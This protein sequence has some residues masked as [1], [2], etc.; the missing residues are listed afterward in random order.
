MDVNRT[1]ESLKVCI[2]VGRHC[3]ECDYFQGYKADWMACQREMNADLGAIADAI[4][5][6][7]SIL[8]M[9]RDEVGD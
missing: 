4:L 6:N 5:E 8:T 3:E 1:L 2:T 9:L 7:E